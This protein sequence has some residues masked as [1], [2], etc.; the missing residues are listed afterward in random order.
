MKFSR[1]AL[2]KSQAIL[3]GLLASGTGWSQSTNLQARLKGLGPL[4][5]PDHLGIKLP[6]GFK[7]RL[8]ATS[9]Q[10]VPLVSGD[11]SDYKWHPAPDGGA[12]F[13]TENGGWVYVSNSEVDPGGGA[14][15]LRFSPEGD[16]EDAYPILDRWPG[17]H[18]P[19]ARFRRAH[20]GR[21]LLRGGGSRQGF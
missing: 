16:V 7:S 21:V 1:R 20:V 2:I 8:V 19:G 14:G 12:C 18:R 5:D 15:A 11:Q 6:K 9:G 17:R 10:E 13:P 4:Q 3:G